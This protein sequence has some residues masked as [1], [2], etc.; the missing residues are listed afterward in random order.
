MCCER[1]EKRRPSPGRCG[2]P[3]ARS[4]TERRLAC[5]VQGC[6]GSFDRRVRP[7]P[8]P[9]VGSAACASTAANILPDR[10]LRT[11]QWKYGLGKL[12][13]RLALWGGDVATCIVPRGKTIDTRFV[14]TAEG[15]T[16]RRSR[17]DPA[18][19]SRSS[20]LLRATLPSCGSLQFLSPFALSFRVAADPPILCS[21]VATQSNSARTSSKGKCP[22]AMRS[23]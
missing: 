15:D 18:P 16:S 13:L 22:A 12:L 17:T 20:A 8:P 19:G 6:K 3:C 10:N 2:P 1:S 11:S 14:A 9:A 4:S 7:G 5:F 23:W 21:Q